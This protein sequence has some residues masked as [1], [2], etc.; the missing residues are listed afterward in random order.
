MSSAKRRRTSSKTIS[1]LPEPSTS[2]N[3][4]DKN[5]LAAAEAED[6]RDLCK[7]A[8]TALVVEF[9]PNGR[10]IRPPF[11]PKD[12]FDAI[13]GLVKITVPPE[14][15]ASL[16]EIHNHVKEE[17]T[18]AKMVPWAGL[19]EDTTRLRA[20]GFLGCDSLRRL[21]RSGVRLHSAE[22][23]GQDAVNDEAANRSAITVLR[24]EWKTKGIRSAI[25]LIEALRSSDGGIPASVLR[26]EE[27]VAYQPNLHNGAR[28]L[29]AHL[30][31]P[32]HEG[33][34]KVIVTVA[35]KGGATILLVGGTGS[36]D[37]SSS[38]EVSQ[39]AWRFHLNEGECYV[40]SR[41]ARDKCLHA[42]LADDCEDNKG[43]QRES[44]NLRFGLHTAEEGMEVTK[45][46]PGEL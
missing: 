1:A 5:H 41:C 32:R 22:K 26:E 15:L 36:G 34:G 46:W 6:F 18:Q 37:D 42:V 19:G 17:V 8:S 30:D 4:D 16:S 39:P 31:W 11:L 33:F 35:I 3:V 25:G 12:S 9:E 21:D 24:N 28:H 7:I 27:L 45:F 23:V 13:S 40:L 43:G 29:A 38:D 2:T 20:F 10:I 44:L 14:V